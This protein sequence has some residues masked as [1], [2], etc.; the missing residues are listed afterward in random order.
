MRSR[1]ILIILLIFTAALILAACGTQQESPTLAEQ[2]SGESAA[3][4]AQ[5]APGEMEEPAH[6]DGDGHDAIPQGATPEHDEGDDHSAVA[7]EDAGHDE[8]G[9]GADEGGSDHGAGAHGIPEEAA[10]VPNP[11]AADAASI[12]AGAATFAATCA[13]CHGDTGLGDGIAGAVL[14]P[15]PANLHADHVQIVPDGGIFYTIQN[16][17]GTGMPAWGETLSEEEIW[18]LVNFIRTFKE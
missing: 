5:S 17:K 6:D 12:A 9:M 1:P 10:A 8:S 14:D 16:G 3:R 13:V 4:I 15:P 2:L 18:N 7:Q 11:I